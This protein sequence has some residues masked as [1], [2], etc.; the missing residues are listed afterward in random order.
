MCQFF[1]FIVDCTHTTRWN[2]VDPKWHFYYKYWIWGNN[3]R[4]HTHSSLG[5]TDLNNS[6]SRSSPGSRPACRSWQ[7][8]KGGLLCQMP[9]SDDNRGISF[10]T[11]LLPLL[12]DT[13]IVW[14]E[15]WIS[16]DFS[17]T[18]TRESP[19]WFLWIVCQAGGVGVGNIN[20][21]RTS[22]PNYG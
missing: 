1:F 19:V 17:T 18:Q 22:K 13:T 14:T 5:R 2:L 7:R 11:L 15:H 8:L 16:C 10:L 9:E 20:K 12:P 4:E 21:T 6:R 3:V